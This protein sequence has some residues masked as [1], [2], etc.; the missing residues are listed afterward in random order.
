MSP[1]LSVGGCH[2]AALICHVRHEKVPAPLTGIDGSGILASMQNGTAVV[3]F[4]PEKT[5]ASSVPKSYSFGGN[6]SYLDPFTNEVV[7]M[8]LFPVTL[9]VNPSPDLYLDYF[10]QRNIL[11]DDQPVPIVDDAARRGV[12]DLGAIIFNRLIH[13]SLPAKNLQGNKAS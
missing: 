5:A 10:M 11:G 9:A 12:A 13:P 6:L 4:I 7:T 1:L 2:S 8:P 3:Q